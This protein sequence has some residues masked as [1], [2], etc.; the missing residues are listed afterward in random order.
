MILQPPP[1]TTSLSDFLSASTAA[2]LL[3][4]AG[5][6]STVSDEA[7][8]VLRFVFPSGAPAAGAGGLEECDVALVWDLGTALHIPVASV[9]QWVG[10]TPDNCHVCVAVYRAS[11]PP[12]SLA[13]IASATS[14]W[15][16]VR[17]T[18][19]S[20][21]STW[22][23]NN[24]QSLN[25][26]ASENKTGSA[27]VSYTVA[28]DDEGWGGYLIRHRHTESPLRSVKSSS[29]LRTG[30]GSNVYVA[31]LVGLIASPGSEQVTS[32]QF[33]QAGHTPE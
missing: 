23:K 18:A 11:A 19:A 31:L 20:R 8:D 29:L 30:S 7:G 12:T 17:C 3:K 13:D 14:L 32:L 9:L 5:S 27:A 22:G 28:Q 15:L 10:G 26:T 25:T 1:L 16:Q 4:K 24:N 2:A 6:T 33:S 21:V